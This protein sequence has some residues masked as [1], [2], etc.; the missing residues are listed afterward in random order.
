VLQGY[1]EY[2]P[3]IVGGLSLHLSRQHHDGSSGHA[4]VIDTRALPYCSQ[5]AGLAATEAKVR[6]RSLSHTLS[7]LA[8]AAT[9]S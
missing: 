8:Q 6:P 3:H 2:E 1:L 5:S 9:E 7:L 4:D